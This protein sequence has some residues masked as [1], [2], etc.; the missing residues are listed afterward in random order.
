MATAG[1]L[2]GAASRPW[3]GRA[4]PVTLALGALLVAA[5]LYS[6]TIGRYALEVGDVVLILWDNLVP[7]ADPGWTEVEEGKRPL[8][9]GRW[10]G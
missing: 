6:V 3:R 5:I 9:L 7:V 10:V 2:A 8:H 4:M 1:P